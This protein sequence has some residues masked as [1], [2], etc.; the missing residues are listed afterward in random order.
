MLTV[1]TGDVILST[2]TIQIDRHTENDLRRLS[3]QEGHDVADV[4]ARLLAR[5]VRSARYRPTYDAEAL[6]QAYA[7]FADEDFAL[8]ESGTAERAALLAE[9]DRG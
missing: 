6:K 1:S 9:E 7:S 3:E 2:L 4:A 5:A 8:A